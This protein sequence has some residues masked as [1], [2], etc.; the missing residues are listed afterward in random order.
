METATEQT[1]GGTI[2]EAARVLLS[3]FEARP[4]LLASKPSVLELGSGTGFLGMSLARDVE[5]RRIVLTEMVQ[6]GALTWL[7][8]NVRRNREA[9]LPLETLSTAALDWSWVD[10]GD[11]ATPSAAREEESD[12]DTHGVNSAKAILDDAWDVIIGS[13]LVYNEVGARMLPKVIA[14]LLGSSSKHDAVCYYA[15]T[16]NRFEFLDKDFLEALKEEGVRCVRVWPE[17]EASSSSSDEAGGD[18]DGEEEEEFTFS[19]ELFPEQR[20]VVFRMDVAGS[21]RAD[22]GPENDATLAWHIGTLEGG[23]DDGE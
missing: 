11:A 12:S 23:R 4:E 1:T 21:G 18:G 3:Y 16:L 7:E 6:G 20:V 9:G 15:H 17:A 19:G 10:A 8:R 14:R 5:T 22:A 13:D 2:W